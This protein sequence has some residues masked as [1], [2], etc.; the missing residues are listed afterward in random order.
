MTESK[1]KEAERLARLSQCYLCEGDM[2]ITLLAQNMSHD[3][4][5]VA[6]G[7]MRRVQTSEIRGKHEKTITKEAGSEAT[8]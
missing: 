1:V 8:S 6:P 4:V 2:G 5:V 7:K 3:N